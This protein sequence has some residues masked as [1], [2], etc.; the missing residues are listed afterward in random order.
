MVKII[1]QEIFKCLTQYYLWSKSAD[2]RDSILKH[3]ILYVKTTSFG[4]KYV[5]FFIYILLLF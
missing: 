3:H 1:V 4:P 2:Y 5:V